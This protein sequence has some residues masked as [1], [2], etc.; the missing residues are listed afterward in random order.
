[1]SAS[2]EIT[3]CRRHVTVY[4]TVHRHFYFPFPRGPGCL[5]DNL[6]DKHQSTTQG[7]HS[8]GVE[9][10]LVLAGMYSGANTREVVVAAHLDNDVFGNNGLH[11][12]RAAGSVP[13]VRGAGLQAAPHRSSGCIRKG[14]RWNRMKVVAW[15]ARSSSHYHKPG[16]AYV[17]W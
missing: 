11:G 8:R 10:Q 13:L 3:R 15:P 12:V 14:V 17:L 2:S 4:L 5:D 9:P 6:D 1:M 16:N 7:H